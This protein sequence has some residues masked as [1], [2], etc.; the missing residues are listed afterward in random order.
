[1]SVG[2]CLF[3]KAQFNFS[4]RLRE[5]ESHQEYRDFMTQVGCSGAIV[6][7]FLFDN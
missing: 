4:N 5:I 2:P 1:M 3:Q 7:L 6:R